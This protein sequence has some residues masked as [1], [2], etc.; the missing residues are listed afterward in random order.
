MARGQ[1]PGGQLYV[2]LDGQVVED[3]AV[4]ESQ[5]G[6][7]MTT[8]TLCLWLSAGKPLVALA[9]VQ[10]WEKGLLRL[11]QAV[12]DIVPAFGVRGKESVTVRQVLTHT[13]GFRS[14]VDL[15]R[16]SGSASELPGRV[17]QARLERHWTPGR[18]AGYHVL[19]GW[20]ALGEI[21]AQVTGVPTCQYVREQVLE[22][23]GMADSWLLLP[24][25]AASR[26]GRRLAGIYDTS[27]GPL[28]PRYQ[29]LAA[30]D[31]PCVPGA[32][33]RG[34]AR[35][36]G[37]FY[38]VLLSGGLGPGGPVLSPVAVEAMVARHR[39]G[40]VDETFGVAMDWGLGLIID[41]KHYGRAAPYGFGPHASPRTFGHGGNQSSVGY[42]DPEYGLAVAA[43]VNGMPGP[44]AHHQRFERLNRA[45]YEDLGLA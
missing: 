24:S 10:L 36:L 29:W 44:E 12:A 7:S 8:D 19:S 1:H 20:Y 22:P 14:V 3:R 38:E 45:I 17:F 30:T 34:P 13:G 9:V 6:V 37:R 31:A 28:E 42:A 41:G 11:D 39:V 5:P 21:V 43:V 33:A 23:A 16:G 35:E 25:D 27:D 32:G 4:G 15:H 40:L 18:R 2:S 26:Y